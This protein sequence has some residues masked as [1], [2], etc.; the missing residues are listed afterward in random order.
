MRWKANGCTVLPPG[1]FSRRSKGNQNTRLIPRPC[2]RSKKSWNMKV[3]VIPI[4]VGIS[5]GIPENWEKKRGKLK[6]T[7][8]IEN[9][10][11]IALLKSVTILW[12]VLGSWRDLLSLK[13]ENR[14]LQLVW[15]HFKEI[16]LLFYSFESF[17]HQLMVFHWSV[18]DSKSPQVFRT[19]LS[20]VFFFFFFFFF[21]T[22]TRSGRLA[23]IRWS[24]CLLSLLFLISFFTTV[25]IWGTTNL[26]SPPGFF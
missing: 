14:S 2:R 26:L 4:I 23:E 13:I 6:I 22:I 25:W 17:S 5:G 12:K 24:V 8:R 19:L 21:L 20:I 10:L 15:K 18:S 9:I 11:I 7:E 16:L 1:F 3:T